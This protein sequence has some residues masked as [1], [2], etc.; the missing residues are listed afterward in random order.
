M[1]KKKY[2]YRKVKGRK[3]KVRCK[4][5]GKKGSKT[6]DYQR[7][8]KKAKKGYK[9][10]KTGYGKAKAGYGKAKATYTK[11][12]DRKK[13]KQR[14]QSEKFKKHSKTAKSLFKQLPG[15]K[16][17]IKKE[18]NPLYKQVKTKSYKTNGFKKA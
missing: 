14:K 17:T 7:F 9:T 3:N 6:S 18:D 2:Y 1:P 15:K 11:I 12:R 5:P 10:A 8:I 4:M 16:K 13:I